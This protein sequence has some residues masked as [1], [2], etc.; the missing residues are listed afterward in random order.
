MVVAEPP[1]TLL[2]CRNSVSFLLLRRL[3]VCDQFSCSG[4]VRLREDLSAAAV[5][6][7]NILIYGIWKRNHPAHLCK[8][9]SRKQALL[10]QNI[11]KSLHNPDMAVPPHLG[12]VLT[13]SCQ[14]SFG[15]PG[16]SSW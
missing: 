13:V 16:D 8:R 11:R 12:P 3:C 15:L 5:V 4:T 10:R 2:S 7:M 6:L 9:K 1:E 14:R